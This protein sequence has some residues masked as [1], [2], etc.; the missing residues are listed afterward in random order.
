MQTRTGEYRHDMWDSIS[1]V[2]DN[3]FAIWRAFGNDAWPAKYLFDDRGR[4]V[5]RW[6][7]EG[8]CDEIEREIRR[9]LVAA[10]P[11]SQLPAVSELAS[12][13]TKRGQPSY[14]GITN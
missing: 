2:I 3:G 6:I 9:L 13:F 12:T 10:H 14:A 11:D 1:V 7:G 5:R 8:S 4:L